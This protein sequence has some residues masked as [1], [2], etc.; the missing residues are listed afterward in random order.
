V[1]P[2]AQQ[3][4]PGPICQQE[5]FMS[6]TSTTTTRI[7]LLAS[8]VLLAAGLTACN[9]QPAQPAATAAAAGPA[10]NTDISIDEIMEAVIMPTT[11]SIWKATQVDLTPQGEKVTA[12]TKDEEWL[13][14]RH[15]AVTLAVATNLLMIPQLKI[16][17]DP[18]STKHADGELPPVEIGKIRNANL[19]AF[20]AH[21]QNL[22]NAAMKAIEAIDKKD[23]EA[24]SNIGGDLDAICEACHMQF[25]YPN[26]G[27]QEGK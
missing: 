25:W 14:L 4:F 11:D 10:F 9:Q 23:V 12:P 7:K 26:Q 6:V 19:A 17:K 18:E 2:S 21:A 24:I 27:K 16:N 13:A 20:A 1:E 8:S 5:A 3:G 15:Q 22:H